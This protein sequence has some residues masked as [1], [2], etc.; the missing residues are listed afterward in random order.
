[1]KTW[2]KCAALILSVMMMASTL[3]GCGSDNSTSSTSSTAG[4]SSA[5]VDS[6]PT[7]SDASTDDGEPVTITIMANFDE[8]STGGEKWLAG[9]E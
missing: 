6:T 9:I 4:T 5:A 3:V 7:E 1:M 8:I 2:K